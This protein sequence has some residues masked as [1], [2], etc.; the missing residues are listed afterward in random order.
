MVTG[1]TEVYTVIVMGNMKKYIQWNNKMK[2]VVDEKNMI[3][4]SNFKKGLKKDT[5]VKTCVCLPRVC[6][7]IVIINL[8]S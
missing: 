8:G 2:Y 3:K 5:L 4:G 6:A 7:Y 1:C